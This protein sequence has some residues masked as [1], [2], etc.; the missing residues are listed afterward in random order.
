MQ[1]PL[2]KK[3]DKKKKDKETLLR[4]DRAGRKPKAPAVFVSNGS[5]DARVNR[6]E[7]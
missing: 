4:G 5:A 2:E 6:P 3:C 1:N 7:E